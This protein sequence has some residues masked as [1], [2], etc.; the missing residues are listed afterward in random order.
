MQAT[1]LGFAVNIAFSLFSLTMGVVAAKQKDIATHRRHV[2]R[3]IGL[4]YGVF[5][6]KY[7]WLTLLSMTAV[8]TGECTYAASVWLSSITSVL[9]TEWAFL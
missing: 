2:I 6:F 8:I 3:M 4:A 9:V 5:S 7:V 1:G